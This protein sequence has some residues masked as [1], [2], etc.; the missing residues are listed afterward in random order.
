[1]DKLVAAGWYANLV[2]G[3]PDGKLFSWR[4][5]FNAIPSI[6]EQLP[7]TLGLTLGGAVFGLLLALLFAIVKINRTKVL[8]PIQAVVVS[9][10]RGTPILV[11]LMLSYYGIPLLLK[12]LNQSY[13]LN[14]N[15]NSIPASVFAITAFAFNEAA[16]TS[17]TIRAAIQA[18]NSGEIEA[19]KSLGMTST[20]IYRRVIIPNAAVIATPTL[21]NTLIGLTKGTSL[22]FNAGIVE[23]FAQAQILGGRDYRYFERFISVAMIYWL[24]NIVIE[25]VGR[26]L[27][28]K[29]AIPSPEQVKQ[30][31]RH[32]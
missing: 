3:L 8:Y 10:L 18:V 2:A 22:A 29:M 7:I 20:Q 32:D 6:L 12:A 17:E 28:K 31:G 14:W 9:F 30:G 5:V 27:E 16:Y 19:A 24:V 21:I 4:A 25:S 26:F 1:M 13:G 23:M 15:V 11:Q